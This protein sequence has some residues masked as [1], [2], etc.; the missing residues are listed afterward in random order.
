MYRVGD[1]IDI[2][3]GPMM[4]STS[5]LGRCTIGAVHKIADINHE[6]SF[7]RVQ[8]VALPSEI[9]INYFAYSILEERA[10]KLV[11]IL[12]SLLLQK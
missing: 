2:S 4:G 6:S 8:G 12:S 7:Y 1:H 5:L 3:R 10:K 9:I 11:N